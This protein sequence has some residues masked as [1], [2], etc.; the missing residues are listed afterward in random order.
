LAL[1]SCSFKR[2]TVAGCAVNVMRGGSGPPVLFL[3]GAGGAGIWLPFMDKLA[4]ATT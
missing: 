3:H 4:E 2:H 1:V